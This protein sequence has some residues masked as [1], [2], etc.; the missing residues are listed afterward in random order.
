MKLHTE[1]RNPGRVFT[2]DIRYLLPDE[3]SAELGQGSRFRLLFCKEGSGVVKINGS[4][5]S[6]VS[7]ACILLNECEEFLIGENTSLKIHG[8]YF[9]PSFM[10]SSFTFEN[11]RESGA[12]ADQSQ[13]LDL[14]FLNGFLERNENFRGVMLTG[15]AS[16]LRI[17]E[18]LDKIN[19]ELTVQSDN[20]WPCRSRSFFIELMNLINVMLKN[21]MDAEVLTGSDDLVNSVVEYINSHYHEKITIA[22]LTELFGTNRT[23]L[24]ERFMKG[25]KISVIDYLTRIRMK[26]ASLLL[27]DTT[28]PVVE[29]AYRTGYEDAAHFGRTFKRETGQSPGQYR[30]KNLNL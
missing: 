2:L 7:P 19:T 8:L 14:Y 18:L 10:N 21:P 5:F 11:I 25:V 28:L 4:S 20:Y 23:T 9:S 26:M 6:V 13:I 17:T 12:I 30:D 1:N 22:E 15:P 24:S 16:A 3:F 29:I 27:R